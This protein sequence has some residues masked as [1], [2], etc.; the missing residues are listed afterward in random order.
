MPAWTAW[1]PAT[2][3]S[4][5]ARLATA[6]GLL[7]GISRLDI[8]GL[9]GWLHDDVVM[10]LPFTPGEAP[11]RF[12]GMQKVIEA[13]QSAPEMFHRFQFSVHERYWCPERATAIL[14]ATS[15]G[16]MKSRRIY[17]N[18][19]LF[20]FKFREDRIAH[21]QEFFNPLLAPLP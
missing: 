11:L 9:G 8:E 16:I 7:D 17:Q 5:S 15:M 3:M 21:W 2:R 1:A 4:A 14:E 13:M 10:E 12:E 18:R 20:M 19:Y 6:E